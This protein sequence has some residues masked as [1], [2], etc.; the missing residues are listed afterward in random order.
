MDDARRHFGPKNVEVWES[1]DAVDDGPDDAVVW[2]HR[3][4]YSIVPF[5]MKHQGL[6][7]AAYLAGDPLLDRTFGGWMSAAGFVKDSKTALQS[8]GKVHDFEVR[9]VAHTAQTKTVDAWREQ[10]QSLLKQSP[11]ALDAANRSADWWSKFW[12]R[13]WIFV[14]GDTASSR[15]TE[16]YVLQ[17]WINACGGR[18]N[19]P[20]K[21]NGSIF[22]V[23][24]KY[25]GKPDHYGPDWREWGDC[26]WWQNTRLPY[27]PLP[28]CG[29]F[30]LVKPLLKFY[31]DV[32]PLC[33]ALRNSTIR[34]RG[35][36][37]QKP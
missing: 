5:T 29:D 11:S 14:E 7:S 1:A 20:I 25:T 37:F 6:E 34:L 33:K 35:S 27:Q 22:T 24:A 36:T 19:Y 8:A 17:R 32:A 26:F 31:R 23:D 2:Y 9:A 3:N 15:F 18:G 10:A 16:A 28:A 4:A 21:F 30:D 12:D 13:S